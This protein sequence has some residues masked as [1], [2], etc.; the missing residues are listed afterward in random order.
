MSFKQVIAKGDDIIDRELGGGVRVKHGGL[1]DNFLFAGDGGLDGEELRVDVGTVHG[2]TDFGQIPHNGGQNAA[3]VDKTGNLH[4]G[5]MREIGDQTRVQHVAAD[6][7]GLTRDDRLHDMGRILARARMCNIA[8]Q[9]FLS[10]RFPFLDLL[11]A[12]AGIFIKRDP[13]AVDQLGI[14]GFDVE[15]IVFGVVLA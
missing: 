13:V 1:I 10:L 4:A 8:L 12:A 11:D 14:L 15:I 9:V 7:V 6:L 2:G 3:F 5:V